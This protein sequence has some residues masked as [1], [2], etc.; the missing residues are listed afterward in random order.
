MFNF[1][2]LKNFDVKDLS[3]KIRLDAFYDG[4]KELYEFSKDIIIP[5]TQSLVSPNPNEDA[6]RG[7]Y[8]RMFLL[9]ESAVFLNNLRSFQTTAMITRSLFEQLLDLK[10]L[11]NDKDGAWTNKYHAF[12][13]ID[14][15]KIANKLVEFDQKNPGILSKDIKIKKEYIENSER[16]ERVKNNILSYWGTTEKGDPQKPGHWTGM[17]IDSRANQFGP[18]CEGLYLE[19]FPNLSLYVH[20]GSTGYA[21]ISQ[22]GL[23]SLFGICHRNIQKIY[24]EATRICAKS[25]KINEAVR[26]RLNDSLDNIL[27]LINLVPGRILAEEQINKKDK[28]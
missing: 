12:P 4:T 8:Y 6:I 23:N 7:T 13:E 25:L 16:K 26:H 19:I 20:S 2:D 3:L 1:D 22:E 17:N 10:F 5:A 18:E 15:V 27:D 14:K 21:G 9:I 28:N 11:S 24:I